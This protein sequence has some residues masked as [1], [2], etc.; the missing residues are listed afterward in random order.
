[1]NHLESLQGL[2]FLRGSEGVT[3]SDIYQIIGRRDM[4]YALFLLSNFEEILN[5]SPIQLKYSA[6]SKRYQ[7]VI[8]HEIILSLEEKKILTP[9][10]SKAAMATLACIILNTIKEEQVTKAFL[11]EIRGTNVNNH[12]KEL[13]EHGY[14]SQDNDHITITNKLI[15]EVDISSLVKQLEGIQK[16]NLVD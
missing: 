4:E 11:K 16:E 14:I 2:L 3:L 7:I 15:T 5:N 12:L 9:L 6:S 1:M 10:L 8:S 13:E